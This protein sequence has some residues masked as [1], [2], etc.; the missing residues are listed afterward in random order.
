MSVAT[1]ESMIQKD[2][3]RTDRL[4]PYYAGDDNAN[5]DVMKYGHTHRRAHTCRNI[6]LNYAVF[7]PDIGYIQGMSDLLAPL[8][9]T[10][11]DESHAFWCFAGLVQRTVFVQ[12]PNDSHSIDTNI[13]R[14]IVVLSSY[15]N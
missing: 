11:D 5:M 7:S 3:V 13:V 10:L 8:L 9:A 4:N 2:V 15:F 6:L 14:A 1:I 12:A